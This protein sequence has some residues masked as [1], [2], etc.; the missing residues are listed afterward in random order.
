MIKAYVVGYDYLVMQMFHLHTN[1][2][3]VQ[4][5]EEADLIVFT[6]GSDVS[7]HLYGEHRHPTTS[8][9]ANRDRIETNIFNRNRTT[10]KVGI[11]RG[12]Q[13]LNVMNGGRLWQHVQ[14]HALRGKHGLTR[15]DVDNH[16]AKTYYVTSTHHQMMR[17]T[18]E[19]I[20]LAKANW[21]DNVETVG[22]QAFISGIEVVFYPETNSLCFQP[23]P[24][25][26]MKGD[27]YT[28]FFEYINK[29]LFGGE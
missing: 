22:E 3:V 19:A 14:G 4:S 9:D 5:A 10:P 17:P 2:E 15:L 27:T 23:H 18:E 13:F 24:E 11:C 12:G 8:S 20:I 7:P 1:Y 29:F 25:Y 6:G 28:L 21:V 16:H 26:D